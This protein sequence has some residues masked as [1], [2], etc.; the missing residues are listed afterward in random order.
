MNKKFV[1]PVSDDFYKHVQKLSVA[2]R[3]T[4][5]NFVRYAL[6]QYTKYTQTVPLAKPTVKKPADDDDLLDLEFDS[7]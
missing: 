2:E 6:E 7:D 4:V 5:T 3:R 1:V